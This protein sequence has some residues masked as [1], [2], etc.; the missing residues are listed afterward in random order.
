MSDYLPEFPGDDAPLDS[1]TFV[2]CY[3]VLKHKMVDEIDEKLPPAADPTTLEG[4]PRRQYDDYVTMLG[5]PLDKWFTFV[6][7]GSLSMIAETA[8]LVDSKGAAHDKRPWEYLWDAA[9]TVVYNDPIGPDPAGFGAAHGWQG[10]AAAAFGDYL[11]PITSCLDKYA[12][13]TEPTTEH[14]EGFLRAA[15]RELSDAFAIEAAFK[16]DLFELAR[17]L[18]SA[19]DRLDRGGGAGELALFCV[20]LLVKGTGDAVAS[21]G[22]IA[23]KVFGGAISFAG[24]QLLSNA[25]KGDGKQR[26]EDVA[27]D[28]IEHVMNSFDLKL[29]EIIDGYQR[30]A[31][32]QA[33]RMEEVCTRIDQQLKALP[34]A[35]GGPFFPKPGTKPPTTT[36]QPPDDSDGGRP[37]PP[38][39]APPG[40]TV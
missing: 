30:S 29:Q 40:A 20:G 24:G 37:R 5:A 14:P 18:N 11:V 2:T 31:I 23:G 38:K 12:G 32:R 8:R 16:R 9:T 28:A 26:V 35:V 17:S 15:A 7:D 21:M 39:G 27:G 34:A 19:I 36:P 22:P 33:R 4:E 6:D 10:A 3:E 1:Y 25:I 13:V